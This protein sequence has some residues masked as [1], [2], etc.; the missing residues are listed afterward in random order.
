MDRHSGASISLGESAA[1]D[2]L[3]EIEQQQRPPKIRKTGLLPARPTEADTIAQN[4]TKALSLK[5]VEYE[6]DVHI[7]QRSL[8]QA[9]S[10]F[11]DL[12][13]SN[14]NV[15]RPRNG[16]V[17]DIKINDRPMPDED[18]SRSRGPNSDLCVNCRTIFDHWLDVLRQRYSLST[19]RIST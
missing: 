10:T 4:T 9:R 6:V 8:H 1:V 18:L 3:T 16:D 5:G 11:G 13:D 19:S 7:Q 2:Y 12:P 15:S 14:I 17:M